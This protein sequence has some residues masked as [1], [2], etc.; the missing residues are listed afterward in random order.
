MPAFTEFQDQWALCAAVLAVG[1]ILGWLARTLP[2]RLKRQAIVNQLDLADTL[3]L[4]NE[5][6]I[7]RQVKATDK[8]IAL[9]RSISESSAQAAELASAQMSDFLASFKDIYGENVVPRVIRKVREDVKRLDGGGD[10]RP[11][12]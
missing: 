9:M 12:D 11:S 3:F 7:D 10:M 1:F 4:I 2:L 6:A 5:D 8:H